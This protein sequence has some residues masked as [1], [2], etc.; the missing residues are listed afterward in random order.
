MKILKI[1]FLAIFILIIL[2]A[3]GAFIF[4]KT[5]DINRYK[6][7]IVAQAASALNRKVDFESAGLDEAMKTE[8]S[9]IGKIGSIQALQ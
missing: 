4:I 5:F 1:M 2:A 8:A 6:P 3:A 9:N 7:Q